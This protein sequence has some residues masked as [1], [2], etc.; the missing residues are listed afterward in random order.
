MFVIVMDNCEWM[1]KNFNP[2]A[3]ELKYMSLW[4]KFQFIYLKISG[5]LSI[6]FILPV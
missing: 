3:L 1:A 6:S 4:F 5:P 2:V